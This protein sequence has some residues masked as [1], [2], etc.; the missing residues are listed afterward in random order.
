MR[1]ERENAYTEAEIEVFGE[2]FEA[3]RDGK[4]P[5]MEE[6]LKRVPGSRERM[7]AVL[8]TVRR[9]CADIERLRREYPDVD[10]ARLLDPRRN[11]RE[12]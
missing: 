2:F 1:S 8:E 11:R 3:E 5:D 7:R 6:Y 10:L 9:L 12:D 4:S